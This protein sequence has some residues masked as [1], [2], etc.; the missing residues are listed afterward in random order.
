VCADGGVELSDSSGGRSGIK[1]TAPAFSVSMPAIS[2]TLFLCTQLVTGLSDFVLEQ[3]HTDFAFIMCVLFISVLFILDVLF[4]IRLHRKGVRPQYPL[5]LVVRA[6]ITGEERHGKAFGLICVQAPIGFKK[7]DTFLDSGANEFMFKDKNLANDVQFIKA[8]IETAKG[9]EVMFGSSAGS[10][11]L[12]FSPEV[13][14]RAGQK[15]RILFADGLAENLSSVG[16]LCD[17]G[18]TVVFDSERSRIFSGRIEIVGEVVHQENRDPQTGLYPLTVFKKINECTQ[19][20]SLME[21]RTNNGDKCKWAVAAVF[22]VRATRNAAI[23]V[24]PGEAQPSKLSNRQVALLA[25]FYVREGMSPLERWHYKCGHIGTKYLKNF[26]LRELRV[27]REPF[28]CEACLKGK[29]HRLGH[30]SSALAERRQYLPGEYIITDH[31]GP[32]HRSLGGHRYLQ[33]FLDLGSRKVWAVP[34][35]SKTDSDKALV[36]VLM[37]ARIRSGRKCKYLRTDGDGVFGR[38]SSFQEIMKKEEFIHERPAPYDHEQSAFIDREC[39]TYL[40]GI[41]TALI[42]S[43]SPS[44]F[45]AEAAIHLMYTRNVLPRIESTEKRINSTDG[46]IN[47]TVKQFLSPD[48]LLENHQRPFNLRHL[49]AFGTQC[50]CYLPIPR[51]EGS[52]GPGQVKSLDGVII[53]YVSGM[54]AY[55]VWDI[56]RKKV[57]EISFHFTVLSEGFFPFLNKRNLPDHLEHHPILFYPTF[58]SVL[59]KKEWELFDFSES[60][61]KE[62]LQRAGDEFSFSRQLSNDDLPV[63]VGRPAPAAIGDVQFNH[64]NE[65]TDVQFIRMRPG[66]AKD[67]PRETKSDPSSLQSGGGELSGLESGVSSLPGGEKNTVQEIPEFTVQDHLPSLMPLLE[68][69]RHSASDFWRQAKDFKPPERGSQDIK[70]QTAPD[71][72]VQRDRKP[73]DRLTFRVQTTTPTVLP[74]VPKDLLPPCTMSEARSS[75]W[76]GGFLQAIE[77]ELTSLE[78]NSTWEYID[79]KDLPV[80]A[81]ILRS[82]FV[83]DIKR[84]ASGEF[85][86]FKARMVAMG[87]SQIEG[88]DY[89]DTFASVM[90]VKTFR[91]LLSIWNSNP[92]YQFEHWDVKT[93]FV[94]A[95]LKEVVYVHQVKGFER[96]ETEGKILRLRKALYGTKQ[97]ANAWQQFL[98]GILK[99][100]GGRTHLKDE[101]MYIFEKDSAWVYLCSHVDDL[102]VLCNAEGVQI[103]QNLLSELKK[104]MEIEN[105]GTV[106]WA[107][108]MRIDRDAIAGVLKISQATYAEALIKEY[109]QFQSKGKDAPATPQDLSEQDLPS[110]PEE[111]SAVARL[112]F[113]SLIGRLWWIALMSRPDIHCALHKCA[114]WQNRPSLKLWKKLNHILKYI[115]RTINLGLVYVRD[116]R[117]EILR[118]SCDS[119]FAT[120]SKHRSRYG[121]YF[122]FLGNLVAWTSSHSTRVMSSSTEAECHAL[123]HTGKEN[124][125]MREFLFVLKLFNPIPPTLILQDNKS[126]I[127]LSTGG[128]S[129]KRSKH[130]GVE[131]DTFREYV[132]LG[133]VRIEYVPTT[134]LTADML[135]K[136]LPPTKFSRFRDEVM[137]A[138]ELQGHFS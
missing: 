90:T 62:V 53:G 112:P 32:Y 135:T 114:A 113:R 125:W 43:G 60:E 98:S 27:P 96:G 66:R 33:L 87:F 122:F 63:E 54:E 106:S 11:D 44:N 115:K 5:S 133:E 99:Y 86:R 20:K 10:A 84:G 82:K 111:K 97:A 8:K 85:L 89:Q 46:G 17:T 104:Q 102:F 78:K 108:N 69:R 49:A 7:I 116:S 72:R 136:T 25:K 121:Y 95:P 109:N 24:Q 81:N 40:E 137:G 70:S 37:D 105:K 71:R 126:A 107:L 123:V 58:E 3:G 67:K 52:K 64:L 19:P 2:L 34:M 138:S 103:R 65:D 124:I 14:F 77:A 41:S 45:W 23:A 79:R 75:P 9:G 76:W 48:C 101:C 30:K 13:Q 29:I 68:K 59:D 134:E 38:S 80:G 110:S 51:R 120:E 28:R 12:Y 93:A 74:P 55:R 15:N 119:S 31:Q 35:K 92:T 127:T 21:Y 132:K 57:R 130:F 128:V 39:R 94:N 91:I 4:I 88:V 118:A 50:T 117:V 100:T 131:F 36:E 26:N 56:A 61:E 73:P 22:R 16:R 6:E 1:S 83:F 129:H 18:L 42:A 47:S